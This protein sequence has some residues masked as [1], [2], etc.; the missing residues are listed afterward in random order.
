MKFE[1]ILPLMREGKVGVDKYGNEWMTDEK[2]FFLYGSTWYKTT[3]STDTILGEW[4][5][6]KGPKK[7]KVWDWASFKR[8]GSS[9]SPAHVLH[10]ATEEQF[11]KSFRPFWGEEYYKLEGTEREV[12]VSE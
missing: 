2:D 1:N 7:I 12:E 10:G 9:G 11:R 6:K 5:I 4:T 8:T 3:P